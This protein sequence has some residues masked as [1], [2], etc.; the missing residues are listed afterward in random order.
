MKTTKEK[1]LP[2]P[3]ATITAN[4]AAAKPIWRVLAFVVAHNGRKYELEIIHTGSHH[5]RPDEL[6]AY[7]RQAI[8]YFRRELGLAGVEF[9]NSSVV[10]KVS[11]VGA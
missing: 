10:G 9:D 6:D 5:P 4:G 1:S 8:A 2:A 7:L 3:A 11:E